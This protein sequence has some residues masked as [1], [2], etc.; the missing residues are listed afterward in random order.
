MNAHSRPLMRLSTRPSMAMTYNINKT[1]KLT[2]SSI[3]RYRGTFN[4][5]FTIKSAKAAY[6]L[7]IPLPVVIQKWCFVGIIHL[8]GL[9]FIVLST[10]ISNSVYSFSSGLLNGRTSAISA[11]AF[12]AVYMIRPPHMPSA[13]IV[14][15]SLIPS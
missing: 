11:W 15:K 1:R 5:R 2:Y 12:R 14:S 6:G 8:D 4:L 9:L 10:R 7:N 13:L 3:D